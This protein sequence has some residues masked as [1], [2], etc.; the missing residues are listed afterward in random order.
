MSTQAQRRQKRR[1]VLPGYPVERKFESL[2]EVKQYLEGDKIA[3]L[4]CGRLFANLG[5]HVVKMHDMSCDEYRELYGIPYTFGLVSSD[6]AER[7]GVRAK[8]RAERRGNEMVEL[9]A[10]GRAIIQAKIVDG[11]YGHRTAHADRQR[12]KEHG[13]NLPH[14]NN[15]IYS[16]DLADRF[17][18]VMAKTGS[19]ARVLGMKIRGFPASDSAISDWLKRHEYFANLYHKTVDEMPTTIRAK[20]QRLGSGFRQE[21]AK[22]MKKAKSQKEAAAILGV[23]Q[24]TVCRHLKKKDE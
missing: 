24:M 19:A 2:K 17:C 22:V 13:R 11:S 5:C 12:R 6:T 9:M 18:G 21:L 20:R 3:C 1:E 16:N 4:L 14:V 7:Y 8:E 15:E 23:D 10:R